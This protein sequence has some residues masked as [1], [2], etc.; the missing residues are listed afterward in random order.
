LSVVFAG[1]VFWLFL[2]SSIFVLPEASQRPVAASALEAAVH[3]LLAQ[4][5]APLLL[6]VSFSMAKITCIVFGKCSYASGCFMMKCLWDCWVR[7]PASL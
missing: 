1:S 5:P 7:Q 6:A 2:Y 4:P 3:L